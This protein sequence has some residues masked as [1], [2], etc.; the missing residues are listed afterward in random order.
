M[1]IAPARRKKKRIQKISMA[2]DGMHLQKLRGIN[3]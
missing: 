2:I 3:E 1:T